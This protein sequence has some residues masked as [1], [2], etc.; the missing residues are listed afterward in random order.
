VGKEPAG[1]L[2]AHDD[3]VKAPTDNIEAY[4]LYLKGR[5]HWNKSNPDD[6]KKAITA[7]EKA[8]ELDPGFAPAYCMLSYCYSFLGS[9]G[10]VPYAEAF[11]KAKD[12]TLKAIEIDPHH[13]ESHLS[14]AT[15]KFM[16]NWDF[17]GAEAS[18]QKARDLGLN[19]SL[20]NQIDGMLMIAL[21]RADDA[22]RKIESALKQEPLSLTMMCMLG[23]AYSFAGRFH[24]ALAQYDK[25]IELDPTFRRAF[26]GKGFTYLA[27]GDYENAV[28]NLET[29]QGMIGHPLK[30]LGG[31]GYAYGISGNKEKALECLRKTQQREE[32]EPGVNMNLEYALINAGLGDFNTAFNHLSKIYEQR[33]SVVCF[34]MIYCMRYPIMDE[35][36]SDPRFQL[37]IGQMG[38]D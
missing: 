20:L 15:I 29:Y 5:Y 38:L 4:N 7:F 30:G 19:S 14:L 22:V 12:C 37:L 34:G 10:M 8:I 13:A 9:S 27:L 16:Q 32:S 6:I 11:S 21:N 24:D 23:E 18:I 3:I 25:V 35:L 17:A 1:Q 33:S 31:L 26:E 28:Q 2:P 36:K